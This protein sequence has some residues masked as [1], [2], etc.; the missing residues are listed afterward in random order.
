MDILVLVDDWLGQQ[1]VLGEPVQA[2]WQ[3]R[4]GVD[5]ARVRVVGAFDD[6]VADLVVDG[7][8]LELDVAAVSR[9]RAGEVVVGR[10]ER[11]GVHVLAAPWARRDELGRRTMPGGA[12]IG[13]HVVRVVD[14]ASLNQM[15]QA[16]LQ[17]ARERL[18]RVALLPGDATAST[19]V[20]G[21]GV[22]VEAGVEVWPGV[23]LLG[24][25]HL[26]AGAVVRTGC[27]LTDTVVGEGAVLEP[28]TVASGAQ[29]GARCHAGPFAHLRP[30]TQLDQDAKVGNFVET[31][32]AHLHAGAKA[33]HLSYLGD[34]EVGAGSNVGAGTITCNYDGARKH[35]TEIGAGVFIGTNSALVAPLRVGDGA[36]VAA[37]STITEDVPDRALAFGRAKQVVLPERGAELLARNK[38]AKRSERGEER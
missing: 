38:E 27:H 26:H 20:I 12:S 11:G 35:R 5:G 34:C 16:V 15:A 25:T 19:V 10:D 1:R 9:A 18:Q 22:R 24:S 36:L 30:G 17:R 21:G 7:A 23:T 33:N 6:H 3:R 31:K 37:G 28:Y 2:W 4:L 14:P 13:Q 8:V 29:I 32:A